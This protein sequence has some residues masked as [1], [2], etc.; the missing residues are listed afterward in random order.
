MIVINPIFGNYL[1][2][3][4]RFPGTTVKTYEKVLVDGILEKSI[5]FESL[6]IS[7]AG[8][9]YWDRRRVEI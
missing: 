4:D 3:E 6:D 9:S 1:A 2:R 5:E 7:I 8:G